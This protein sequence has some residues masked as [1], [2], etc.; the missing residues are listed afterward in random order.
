MAADV[1][2]L[3]G[4][5]GVGDRPRQQEDAATRRSCETLFTQ[6][7][8][9]VQRAEVEADRHNDWP[10][11]AGGGH[12]VI[13]LG[14]CRG[15]VQADAGRSRVGIS[16]RSWARGHGVRAIGHV[17]HAEARSAQLGRRGAAFTGIVG[18]RAVGD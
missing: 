7:R 15:C 17:T 16:M 14:Y 8:P 1:G 5:G 9:S 4:T 10:F 3:I 11:T 6:V 12:E 18:P 13:A 2:L